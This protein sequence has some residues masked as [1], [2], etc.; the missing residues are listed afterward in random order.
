MTFNARSLTSIK[1]PSPLTAAAVFVFSKL[2]SAN[3]RAFRA[4]VI[5]AERSFTISKKKISL[6][7]SHVSSR[8]HLPAKIKAEV[9]LL[10]LFWFLPYKAERQ[11]L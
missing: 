3:S 1:P 11:V 5:F 6:G 10:S 2:C 7:L 9:I 4:L 8:I